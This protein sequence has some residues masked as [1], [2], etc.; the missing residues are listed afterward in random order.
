VASL[1]RR[2]G[3]LDGRRRHATAS[4]ESTRRK[5]ALARDQLGAAFGRAEELAT[6]RARA[7]ELHKAMTDLARTSPEAGDATSAF[8]DAS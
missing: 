8:G 6:K 1:E 3:G 7:T 2:H 4:A 5:P